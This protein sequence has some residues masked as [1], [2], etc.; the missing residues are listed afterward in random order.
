LQRIKRQ[1]NEAHH[2]RKNGKKLNLL[3]AKGH[4][5]KR[6]SQAY[7]QFIHGQKASTS[8]KASTNDGRIEFEHATKPSS[9]HV[10]SK[11]R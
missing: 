11:G 10:E 4:G 6:A 3:A 9:K 2:E 8:Y 7:F 1:R 5:L